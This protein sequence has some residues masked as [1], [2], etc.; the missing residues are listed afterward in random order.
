[1]LKYHLP[2]IFLLAVFSASV[3]GLLLSTGGAS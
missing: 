1:M 3:A 2:L